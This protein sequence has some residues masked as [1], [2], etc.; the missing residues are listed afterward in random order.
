MRLLLGD[1]MGENMPVLGVLCPGLILSEALHF[2]AVTAAQKGFRIFSG[3][4]R[5]GESG[6]F[7]RQQDIN[8]PQAGGVGLLLL[9]HLPQC[10]TFFSGKMPGKIQIDDCILLLLGDPA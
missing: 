7:A 3:R 6:L 5:C 2:P 10:R 4:G 9:C 8:A 1:Q